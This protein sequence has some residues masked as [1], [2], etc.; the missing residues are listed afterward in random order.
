MINKILILFLGLVIGGIIGYLVPKQNDSTYFE[1]KSDYT[2]QNGSILKS[3]TK[4][5]YDQGF[6]EGFTRYILYVN[7]GADDLHVEKIEQA[8]KY[9]V[10][11]YWFSTQN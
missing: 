11:P 10:F 8:E 3:G 7:I 2:S 4:L 1:L 9:L 6:S 5:C